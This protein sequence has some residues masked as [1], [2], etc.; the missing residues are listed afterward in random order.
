MTVKKAV[1]KAAVE[2]AKDQ[3]MKKIGEGQAS[4]QKEIAKVKKTLDST[5]KKV[6][7]YAKKSPEKAALI[8]AA[9]GAALAVAVS[10]FVAGSKDKGGK[11]GTGAKK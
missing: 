8:S 5:Y 9:V 7:D 2:M 6:E 4:A 11:K 3:M 1:K 10:M